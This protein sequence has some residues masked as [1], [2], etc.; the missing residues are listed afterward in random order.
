M[1]NSKIL[2]DFTTTLG[3]DKMVFKNSLIP[4]WA[5]SIKC[6]GLILTTSNRASW[7]LDN[8][9]IYALFPNWFALAMLSE[10]TYS[11]FWLF[12]STGM[13]TYFKDYLRVVFI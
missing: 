6:N 13:W 10:N 1:E 8:G 5:F 4:S 3:C 12:I 11:V 7:I 2:N 9:D